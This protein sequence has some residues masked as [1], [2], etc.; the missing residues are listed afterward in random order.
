MNVSNLPNSHSS[1]NEKGK[2]VENEVSKSAIDD[3]ILSSYESNDIDDFKDFIVK[4]QNRL[5]L[6]IDNNRNKNVLIEK[7]NN[8][9]SAIESQLQM[10]F[11]ASVEGITLHENGIIIEVSPKF[12]ELFGYNNGEMIGMNVF[13]TLAPE[14]RPIAINN[15]EIG[16]EEPYEVICLRKDASTF[17]GEIIGKQLELGKKNIRVAAVRDI[18]QRKKIELAL[19]DSEEKFR[20]IV[21]NSPIFILTL[22]RNHKILFKNKTFEELKYPISIGEDVSNYIESGY[23]KQVQKA[24]KEVFQ[25]SETREVEVLNIYGFYLLCQFVPII[26]EQQIDEV[27]VMAVD[28]TKRKKEEEKRKED[29]IQYRMLFDDAPQGI[30]VYQDNEVKYANSAILKIFKYDPEDHLTYILNQPITTF[31][32]PEV[33]EESA[34][35]EGLRLA[36]KR[37]PQTVDTLGKKKNGTVFPIRLNS[38]TTDF[39]GKPAV[40]TFIDD[41]TEIKQAEIDKIKFYT[42]MDRTQKLES[43]GILAGGIAHDFNNLLMGIMG[44]ASL[45]LLEL[46]EEDNIRILVEE[47]ELISQK[48][49]NLSQQMLAYSG[50]GKFHIEVNDLSNLIE[51]MKHLLDHSISKSVNIRYDLAENIPAVE[52]DATQIQQVVLNFVTNASEAIGNKAGEIVIS[53][54][55]VNVNKKYVSEFYYQENIIEGEYAFLEVLDNGIGIDNTL[56]QQIF[57]PFFSI[58]FKGRGLG[59]AVVMGIV[60]GHKAA[61][62]VESIPSK[63]TTFTVLLPCTD[64]KYIKKENVKSDVKWTEHL[65]KR[66]IL[67]CDD[68]EAIRR[69]TGKMLEQI[70]FETYVASNGPEALRLFEVN[71]EKISLVLLDL[72]MP[73]MDGIEVYKKINETNNKIPVILMSGFNED[74]LTSQFSSLGLAGVLQKPFTFQQ[75]S[76]KLYQALG[77]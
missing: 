63:E 5:K 71:R 25:T 6:E 7:L 17:F 42:Q 2:N 23:I 76:K 22:D 38:K 43:L 15:V 57:D 67:I 34:Y 51:E 49:A 60:K 36:G 45:A 61:I 59:L 35:L 39:R 46:S 53:T 41:I 68:E 29:E 40:L 27:M 74:E 56:L 47:I 9:I 16:L 44:N 18:T 54:G 77:L 31:L 10:L 37:V 75:L 65:T 30:V 64:K 13:D 50:K 52:V 69:V 48:A 11:M 12:E 26:E 1:E 21:E 14:S 62:R 8:K 72:T 3:K 4:L 58:K 32:S 70:G 73:L 33:Y 19:K 24:L 66:L 28:I 55:V 20:I